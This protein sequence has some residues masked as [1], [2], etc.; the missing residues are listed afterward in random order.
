MKI[1]GIEKFR[2][3]IPILAG[4]KIF[5]LPVYAI[6]ILSLCILALIGV[7]S[8]PDLAESSGVN[9]ILL[10]FFPLIGVLIIGAIGLVLIY[11]MWFWRRVLKAKY[12]PLSYQHIFLVGFAGVA[13]MI[14]LSVNLYVHF[15]V[16]SPIFWATSQLK[17]LAVPLD[18][19]FYSIGAVLFCGK[20]ALTLLCLGL[21]ITTMIRSIQVF[22]FDYMTVIYL[23]FPEESEIQDNEIY[24]VLRHPAYAGMLLIGLGG[25]FYTFTLY[26]I[27]FFIVELS[28]FYI[29]IH[30]VEEKEL[31]ERFGPSYREYMKKVPAFLVRPNKMRIFF[32][33]LAGNK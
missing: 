14:S 15:W 22:G 5:L 33:F 24:S 29:H 27:I 30:F 32:G 26:S 31:I 1:K 18:V 3:K 2:E 20:M 9:P 17:F 21:G 28:A 12:G 11:Q 23:Y 7:D 25:V 16:Y 10:S 8:I 4:K 19:Y 13:C 6:F